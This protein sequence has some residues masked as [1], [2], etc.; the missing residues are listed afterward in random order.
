MNL[1]QVTK[2]TTL[3]LLIGNIILSI[4]RPD[5]IV[6]CLFAQMT[7]CL[8]FDMINRKEN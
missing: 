2:I 4:V 8:L 5:L 7:I 6:F 1:F 3:F